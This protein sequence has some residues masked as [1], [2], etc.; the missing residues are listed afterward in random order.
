[1]SEEKVW[2]LSCGERPIFQR[3]NLSGEVICCISFLSQY[4]CTKW[5]VVACGACARVKVSVGRCAS[6]VVWVSI[7]TCRV[8][9]VSY[10]AEWPRQLVGTECRLGIYKAILNVDGASTRH[11]TMYVQVC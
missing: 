2:T 8:Y 3:E 11:V 9:K 7:D 4:F 1:M 5:D 6:T 10:S